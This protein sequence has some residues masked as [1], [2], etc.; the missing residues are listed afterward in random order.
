[1]RRLM[2]CVF[3]TWGIVVAAPV[4]T[5]AAATVQLRTSDGVSIAAT[6]YE[7]AEAA[8][9]VV[10]VPM[11]TRT[12]DDWRAFAERLNAAGLSALAVDLRGHGGS[13]GAAA[14]APAMALDV[15]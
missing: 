6:W 2:A 9:A 13:S 7:A 11:Y 15:R 4:T 1:M 10:L 5:Q 14:P 3:V 8:P 12:R